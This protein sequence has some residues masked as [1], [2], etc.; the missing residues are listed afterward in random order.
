MA[1]PEIT[2]SP[3]SVV[4]KPSMVFRIVVPLIVLGIGGAV[5]FFLVAMREKPGKVAVKEIRPLVEVVRLYAE[6][7]TVTVTAHGTTKAARELLVRPQVSGTITSLHP[8]LEEGA[9]LAEGSLLVQIDPRDYKIALDAE[10]ASLQRAQLELTLEKGSQVVAEREWNLL[11]NSVAVTKLGQ[12]LA[13][14]KPHLQEK[15]AA[16]QAA[17]SMV[18]KAQLDL[19]RTKIITPFDAIVISEQVEV[20][21]LINP[22]ASVATLV[23]T[24]RFFVEVRVPRS[25]LQWLKFGQTSDEISSSKI[26]LFLESQSGQALP[27]KARLLRVLGQVD[28]Q[29]RMARVLLEVINPL[30][31]SPPLLLGTYVR[32]EIEGKQLSKV[33]QV[34]REAVYEN[35]R[36]WFVDSKGE[37]DKLSIEI[38]FKKGK[39]LYARN[40][41]DGIAVVTSP[42][43]NPFKGTAVEIVSDKASSSTSG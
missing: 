41:R 29:G 42:L 6:D 8:Q 16:L 23:A 31:S 18:Q 5:L 10:R 37:L 39:Y 17:K 4:E 9:R 13:L 2:E 3:T 19:D 11:G 27:L 32:A 30:E 35:N 12:E 15:Q 22:Q 1:S 25:S 33:Y 24:D 40:L 21:S 43:A 28:P 26:A 38:A 34:P 36:V 7:Q 14:R 20:G